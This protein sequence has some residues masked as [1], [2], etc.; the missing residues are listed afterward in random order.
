MRPSSVPAPGEAATSVSDRDALKRAFLADAGFGDWR[1]ERLPGDASTRS[2]ERLHGPDGGTRI[3]MDQPPSL[4]SRPCP[5]GA[6]PAERAELGFNAL[7]RLAAGRVDAFVAVAGFLNENGF[8]TP[9]VEAA[10]P[11]AG[12]ALLEDL[13][14]D[15][16]AALLAQGAADEAELYDAAVDALV[17]LHGVRAPDVLDASGARWPLLTYDD[18]ALKFAGDL[19][20]EWLPKFAGLAS[21]SDAAASEWEAVWAPVRARGEATADVF[22]HRDYHAENLIW[23]PGRTGAA[24]VGMLDFQDAVLANRAWDFSMLLHD[25]RRD[26]SPELRARGLARYLAAAPDVD[27]EAFRRDFHALGALN[28]C[29][30]LGVFSRLVVRDGKRRYQTFMPRMWGY[31]AECLEQPGLEPLARWFERH[32]PAEVRR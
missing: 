14:D 11:D 28:V 3:L 18:V 32:V 1:R 7:Y 8:S 27:A 25:A 16:F 26:V 17:D 21:F 13:G 23:L 22:C 12:L 30:I 9:R 24:R 31:L 29:R 15:L 19:L 6:T 5:P 20:I 10:A 4:E 2:Y